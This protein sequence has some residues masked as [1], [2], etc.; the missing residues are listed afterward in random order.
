MFSSHTGE[1]I[2]LHAVQMLDQH[3]LNQLLNLDSSEFGVGFTSL[4]YDFSFFFKAIMDE[5]FYSWLTGL[6]S[7]LRIQQ[8]LITKMKTKAPKVADTRWESMS[9]VL[10][11]I[12]IDILLW[13]NFILVRLLFGSNIIGWT[14]S[15]IGPEK[16]ACAPPLQ[17]WI[18]IIF[19]AKK[20]K[21]AI[22]TFRSLE[23]LTT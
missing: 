23:G 6:I 15:C 22:I 2:Y 20:S 13:T 18:Y 7:Y 19:V 11:S 8:T 5:Q 3:D 10:Y 17:W 12:F 4:I 9:K 1:Q 21:E 16:P 14:H